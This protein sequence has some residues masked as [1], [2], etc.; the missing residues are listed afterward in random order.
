MLWNDPI[1]RDDF[2]VALKMLS[3]EPDNW[4]PSSGFPLH[5]VPN[6]RRGTAYFYGKEAI[7]NFL[8]QNGLSFII[9]AH[10]VTRDGFLFHHDGKAM[11]IFR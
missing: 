3:P 2:Q 10:K 11:T 9:R 7:D 5:F 4:F 1:S 8:E 6:T